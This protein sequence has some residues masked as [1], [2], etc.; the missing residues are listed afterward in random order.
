MGP[1]A[2]FVDAALVDE[3]A[4]ELGLN[5]QGGVVYLS[6]VAERY[7]AVVDLAAHEDFEGRPAAW[8]QALE[9]G[10]RFWWDRS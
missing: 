5:Q 8:P 7:N 2:V 10:G 6:A 3:G 1:H 9:R 4:G